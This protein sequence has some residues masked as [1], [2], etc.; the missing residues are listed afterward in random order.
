MTKT[1]FSRHF[2]SLPLH[3]LALMVVEEHMIDMVL[4]VT[5]P[6]ICSFEGDGRPPAQKP[7]D[8]TITGFKFGQ[9][10]LDMRSKYK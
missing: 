5:F 7:S 4:A 9:E 10:E 8:V 6:T 2:L 3:S 1:N